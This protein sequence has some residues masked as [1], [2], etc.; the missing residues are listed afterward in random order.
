MDRYTLR[1]DILR[2]LGD[3]IPR[4]QHKH[5]PT[6][7]RCV[8][9]DDATASAWVGDHAWGCLACG[10]DARPLRDLA[11]RL[12]LAVPDER[13]GLTLA[14][15]A[16]RKGF[17]VPTLEGFGVSDAVVN[18]QPC[19][20]MPYRDAEGATLRVKYRGPKGTWWAGKNLPIF[21]YGLDQLANANAEAAVLLV[22]G[23]SDCHAAWHHG[24]VAVGVPGAGQW[25]REWLPALEGRAVFVWQE[26]DA[27]GETFVRKVAADI[28]TARVIVPPEGVK[29]LCDWRALVGAELP[30]RLEAAMRRARPITAA[31]ED[32]A[33]VPVT[34]DALR[35]LGADKL[36]PVDAVPTPLPAWNALCRDAGG[37]M[38]WAR[39]WHI[40]LA[41]ATGQ[42]KSLL[43]LNAV[44]QAMRAGRRVAFISLEMSYAQLVT[45]ALAIATGSSVRALEQGPSFDAEA[46]R[47]ASARFA[48][49]PGA[50]TVNKRRLRSLADVVGAMRQQVEQFGAE[51]VVVD[52]LQLA[53][54]GMASQNV[55]EAVEQISHTVVSEASALNVVSL[56]L[57]Q[58]N[59]QTSANREAP[60]T[61]QGLMGGS[62]LENDADQVALL[63]HSRYQRTPDGADTYLLV[64]KNRHGG[65]AQLPIRWDYRTLQAFERVADPAESADAH[66]IHT[67]GVASRPRGWAA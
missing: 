5:T 50:L 34:V 22:E 20:A 61:P 62:S 52:Y 7:F 44:A 25:R 26:P 10:F 54:T 57:S 13:P 53:R 19:L 21:L 2:A 33:F 55:S 9:H 15:Y 16:D 58:Y 49:L 60:P 17:H 66:A 36:A 51:M 12:G 14:E 27:G 40:V 6:P 4:G 45:R 8:E 29:D 11:E 63:D 59:R 56:G 38:G 28:P 46:W 30:V 41:G 3:R 47:V 24:I 32:V 64:A 67:G 42:G 31:A 1:A 48:A 65:Q 18:G 39:G 37:G 35:E 23:E 43:A